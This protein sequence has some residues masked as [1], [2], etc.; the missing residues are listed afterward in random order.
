M[1]SMTE[2]AE[3]IAALIGFLDS[4]DAF[5]ADDTRTQGA[6][7][8]LHSVA[9]RAIIELQPPE[10][11]LLQLAE[12]LQVSVSRAGGEAATEGTWPK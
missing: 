5:G 10:P 3:L 11:I 4:D 6:R 12:R 2:L 1:D 7:R 9:R 8:R